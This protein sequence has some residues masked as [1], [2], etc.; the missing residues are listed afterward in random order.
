[1]F[2]IYKVCLYFL[3]IILLCESARWRHLLCRM[4]QTNKYMKVKDT[5]K[6]KTPMLTKALSSL[7]HFNA[8]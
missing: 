4:G 3:H 6:P 1:M 2:C 7:K 8:L 5:T